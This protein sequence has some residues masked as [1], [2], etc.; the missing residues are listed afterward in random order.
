VLKRINVGLFAMYAGSFQEGERELRRVLEMNSTYAKPLLALGLCQLAQGNASQ[1]A[2][3]YRRLQGF[4]GR[5]KDFAAIGLA[6]LA[7]YEGRLGDAIRI[8]ETGIS[9]DLAAKRATSAA[10]KLVALGSAHA[11]ARRA[12]QA[13]LAADRATGQSRQESILYSAARIYLDCG[14]PAKAA[15]LAEELASRVEPDP[16]AFAKLILAETRLRAGNPAA[17][18]L[19]LQE[20]RLVADTWLGR[21]ALGRAYLEAG[22]LPEAHSEL[23]LCLKRRGEATAVFL[24][25]LPTYRYLPAV[26]YHLGRVQ[27]GM[28][29]AGAAESY[30]AFLAA[31]QKDEGDPLVADARRRLELLRQ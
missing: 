11:T 31:R 22:K 1:A 25:D 30:R 12:G 26:Y 2:E 19:L 7:L 24:D 14:Q 8:L 27:E 13:V 6:D 17:A 29:S 10:T 18:V 23:E 16:R 9:E 20:A 4:P 3:S 21:F 28:K 15:A 5:G